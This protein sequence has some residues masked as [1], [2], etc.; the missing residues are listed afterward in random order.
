MLEGYDDCNEMGLEQILAEEPE[1]IDFENADAWRE[2]IDLSLAE[3][4]GDLYFLHS[5]DYLEEIENSMDEFRPEFDDHRDWQDEV[6][7]A[8]D[9]AR[10]E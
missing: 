9:R 5:D 10:Q 3:V 8:I 1:I 6:G 2:E 4:K 7:L